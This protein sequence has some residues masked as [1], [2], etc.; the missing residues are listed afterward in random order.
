MKKTLIALLSV[1]V[2]APAMAAEN[3]IGVGF[4]LANGGVLSIHG[5]FDV[6]RAV[7]GPV[8]ARIGFDHYAMNYGWNGGYTWSY[9]VFYGGAYYD[10]NKA[11]QLDRRFHPFVGLGIGIG[12]ASCSGPACN[13]VAN[14]SVG[15]L[16]FIGGLQ[17]EL[18]PKVDAEL[19]I[20]GWGGLTVGANFKY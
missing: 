16:Y 17:Y 5:D 11:M 2:I 20:N 18:T 3:N 10:L 13:Q 9:N 8:M 14:P 19:N 1:G 7:Q 6:A 15:G 12:S 4:G